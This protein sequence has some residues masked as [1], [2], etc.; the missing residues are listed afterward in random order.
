MSGYSNQFPIQPKKK[1]TVGRLWYNG[2]VILADKPFPLLQFRKRE[3]IAQ[4]YNKNLFKIT[5]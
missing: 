1:P 5:Y 2:K 3:L 4:G